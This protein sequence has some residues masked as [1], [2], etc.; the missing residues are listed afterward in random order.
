MTCTGFELPLA[1]IATV[2]IPLI[3]DGSLNAFELL[4]PRR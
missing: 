1:L 2:Q 4:P 3:A